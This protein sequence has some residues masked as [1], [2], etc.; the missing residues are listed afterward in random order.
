MGWRGFGSATQSPMRTP[1]N[2]CAPSIT[3]SGTNALGLGAALATFPDQARVDEEVRRNLEAR[4]FTIDWFTRRG[5]SPTDSHCNFIFVD[6]GRPATMFRE[7]CA[8]SNVLIARDFP[9]FEKTHVRISIGTLGE[10]KQAVQVFA[11]VLGV[12][13]ATVSHTS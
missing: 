5:F 1:S 7:S 11:K 12:R 13:P 2:K 9:P 10:M 6:I 4:Q 8:K 3:V